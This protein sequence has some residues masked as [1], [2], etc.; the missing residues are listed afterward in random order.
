MTDFK[1]GAFLPPSPPPPHTPIREQP[2]KG[3][4]IQKRVKNP[5]Y[6]IVMYSGRYQQLK[7][8]RLQNKFWMAAFLINSLEHLIMNGRTY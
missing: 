2:R 6:D 3:P 1:E 4:S 5:A 8:N 7:K